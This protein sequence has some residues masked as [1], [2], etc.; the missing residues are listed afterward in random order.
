MTKND[1]IPIHNEV[2]LAAARVQVREVARRIGLSLSDQSRISLATSSLA[3]A[4]G[5]GREGHANGQVSIEYL[6]HGN[7]KGVRVICKRSNCDGFI[8]PAS[9]FS[10]ERWMVDELDVNSPAP[11]EVEVAMIKWVAA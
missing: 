9:Y 1:V 3:T 4:L 8:P 5:L 6:N 11:D 7:R 10:N 2:D